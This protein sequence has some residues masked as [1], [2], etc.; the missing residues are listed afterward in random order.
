MQVSFNQAID[1][2]CSLPTELQIPSYHPYYVIADAKRELD[3]QP[4]FFVY[5][6]QENV[7]YHAAHLSPV[8][9]TNYFDIQSPYGYGGP[10]ATTADHDFLVRA[11][12]SYCSWCTDNNVLVEFIRFHPV[13]GNEKYYL[14]KHCYDRQ[15][16]WIDLNRSDLF[17]SYSVRVRTAIRK[18]VKNEV[19]V[20]WCEANAFLEVFPKLYRE[21]MKELNADEF[22][23][24]SDVYFDTLRNMPKAKFALCKWGEKVIAGAIFFISD[25]EMEYHLSAAD[26]IGKDLCA[27]NL[28]IHE[29][30]LLGQKMGCKVFHL[31]GGT[32][33]DSDNPLLFFKSG[34]SKKQCSFHFGHYLHQPNQYREMK[35]QWESKYNKVSARI[36]FYRF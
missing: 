32:S 12:Q 10:I 35:E 14:G 26:G 1:D 6:E 13:L 22:Y 25:Y 33:C 8:L 17:A 34:F 29:A 5:K 24:F 18:A 20:E 9:E 36:L 7:Y 19:V 30:A 16:V 11:W 15:T 23:L 3:L 2:Y 28:M 27:T 21:T 31:G 4:I